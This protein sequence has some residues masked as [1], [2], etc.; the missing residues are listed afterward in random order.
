MKQIKTLLCLGFFLMGL[1]ITSFSQV[2][3]P[4]V[5]VM[6]ARYKYLSSVDN[7][8]LPQPVKMLERKAA[9]FDIKNSEYYDDEYD[10]YYISFYIPDGYILA[11]YNNNGKLLHTAERYKNIALPNAVAQ[12]ISKNYSGW[13][14]PK[15]VYLVT[16]KEDE[17]ATKVWK[18]ILKKGDKRLRIK[19]DEKGELL[20]KK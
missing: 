1:V 12:T 7:R 18:I 19:L 14:V 11:T 9:E 13:S 20:G 3:L 6:A 2:N 17:G 10:E 8:E 15:D 16:Y 5:F 4:E